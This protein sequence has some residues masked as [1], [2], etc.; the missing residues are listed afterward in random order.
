MRIPYVSKLPADQRFAVKLIAPALALML[1]VHGVPIVMGFTMSFYEFP[2]LQLSEWF[3]PELFV[4][5]DHYLKVFQPDTIYGTEFWNSLKA[6]ILY[7]I[8]SVVGIYTLGLITAV[9]LNQ[10]FRGKLGARTAVLVPWVAPIV[11]T[12]LTWRMMF[13]T[14]TGIINELLSDAGLIGDSFF[15]LLGEHS[16][17]AIII[18]NVWRQFPWA[19]I[20]LYAGLQSIPEQL[21]EAAEVDGA[22]RWQRFRYVTLPMLK[23]V[24]FV[25]LLLLFLWTMINFT[26]PYVL[27]GGSPSDSA[28]VLMLLIYSF[29]F[30]QS[31]Y[32][33]GA[34]LSVLL[35]IVSMVIAWIYYHRVVNS[36]FEGGAI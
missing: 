23:P 26:V 24:S 1:V 21:Y 28:N 27:L 31:A 22:G 7:T 12:L 32:G 2:S 18:A 33:I 14:D 17:W 10:D 4:G 30:S 25:I 3:R 11:P 20:M 34:A 35:F 15:W 13:R 19:A 5:L 36:E 8:G 9:A 16:L 6:T 29:G